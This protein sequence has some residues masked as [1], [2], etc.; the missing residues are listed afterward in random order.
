MEADMHATEGQISEKGYKRYRSK[1]LIT[2][3][4]FL[5]SYWARFP[6]TLRK[7]LGTRNHSHAMFASNLCFVDPVLVYSEIIGV[8][9]MRFSF[10]L[11]D[12]VLGTIKGSEETLLQPERHLPRND[13]VTLTGK[14]KGALSQR[15]DDVYALFESYTKM[16]R[17]SGEKDIADRYVVDRFFACVLITKY[18][19][20]THELLLFFETHGMPWQAVD[21]MYAIEFQFSSFC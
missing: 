19:F 18:S 1:P 17:D 15:S 21:H 20:R 6:E 3:E 10:H 14:R 4:T 2:F 5:A 16:K 11:T 12:I 8:C 9:V 13:Y 7:G